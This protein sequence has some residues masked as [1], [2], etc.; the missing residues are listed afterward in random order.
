M[1]RG[2]TEKAKEVS[3]LDKDLARAKEAKA[4]LG[5]LLESDAVWRSEVRALLK[6]LAKAQKLK[7]ALEKTHKDKNPEIE[8]SIGEILL[9]LKMSSMDGKLLWL[10]GWLIGTSALAVGLLIATLVAVLS[11]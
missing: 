8:L 11:I 1:A 4:R 10:L 6:D 5:E 2:E 9:Y 7:D 3:K